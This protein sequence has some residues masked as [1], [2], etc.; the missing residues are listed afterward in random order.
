MKIGT[1]LCVYGY[2]AMASAK[3]FAR[4]FLPSASMTSMRAFWDAEGFLRV[5]QLLSGTE[6]AALR[7]IVTDLL[8]GK[9]AGSERHRYDLGCA[10][11]SAAGGVENITQIMW[12]SDLHRGLAALPLRQRLLDFV[13]ALMGDPTMDIDY[14]MVVNKA[15]H[16]NTAT[17]FHQDEAYGPVLEDK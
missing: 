10:G 17:K 12:P 7:A 15:P 13:R 11:G 6:V 14:D 4:G 3:P 2:M 8:S 5:D 1:F 16:T 9:V